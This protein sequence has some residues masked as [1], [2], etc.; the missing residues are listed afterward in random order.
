MRNAVHTEFVHA[1]FMTMFIV[2]AKKGGSSQ[3]FDR[4]QP[5]DF[6]KMKQNM[7]LGGKEKGRFLCRGCVD[8]YITFSKQY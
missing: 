5:P 6:G 8:E 7:S 3:E 2:M 1:S 4:D